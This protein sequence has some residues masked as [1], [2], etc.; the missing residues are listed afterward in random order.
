MMKSLSG[1][2]IINDGCSGI[3]IFVNR[4]RSVDIKSQMIQD[5]LKTFNVL[6]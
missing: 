6:I 1:S 4:T 3:I 5:R 2:F